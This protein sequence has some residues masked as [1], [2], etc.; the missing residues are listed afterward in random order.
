MD[1]IHQHEVKLSKVMLN[2]LNEFGNKLSYLG[3]EKPENRAA[4]AAINLKGVN[5]HEVA[6]LLDDMY[7]IFLRSG[8]HC[9]HAF[10]H[11]LDLDQG[12][13]RPSWYLY[14]TEEEVYKFLEA[15]REIMDTLS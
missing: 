10:H 1:N 11:S 3:P 5:P 8:Y 9:T 6:I 2:G 13:L 12:T 15:L 4:L 14:N 7:N